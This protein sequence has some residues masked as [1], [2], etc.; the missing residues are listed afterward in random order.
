MP[1][2]PATPAA[3]A[4]LRDDT[5]SPM[6]S[7][8]SGGGPMNVT[9]ALGDGPGEVGVLRE[10]AVAG[11][12]GLGARALDDVEDRGGVEVAL[13]RR[14]AAEGVGLVG[15]AD[16]Q[17]VAVELGV[18]GHRGDAQLLAGADDTDGDLAA[19]G[20]QDLGEHGPMF[21]AVAGDR[22]RSRVVTALA[23]SRFADIR[24]VAET[25]STNADVLALAREGAAEGRRGRGRP[26]DRRRGRRGR[27]WKAPPGASLLVSR[28]AAAAGRRR[29]R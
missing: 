26:P 18:H 12:H 6:T 4:A 17:R 1:G 10:E 13:G 8:A 9:P 25:G 5:L 20:D 24:W 2:T 29:R 22:A 23:A 28:P 16:V 3:S 19:V 27:S 21:T 15:E 7:I 14:L 11:V